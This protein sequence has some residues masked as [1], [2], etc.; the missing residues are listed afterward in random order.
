MQLSCPNPHPQ[1]ASGEALEGI[2]SG[3]AAAGHGAAV[4]KRVKLVG[5]RGEQL[6]EVRRGQGGGKRGWQ[7]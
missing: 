6:L 4:L 5:Y 1:A 3:L 2:R 7:S